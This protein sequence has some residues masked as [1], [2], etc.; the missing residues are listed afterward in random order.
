VTDGAGNVT[1]H[2]HNAL[3]QELTL[4]ER[5]NREVR[6]GEGDYVTERRFNVDGELLQLDTPLGS[7]IHYTYDVPGIDRYREGNVLEVRYV[8]DLLSAGGRGDGHG[9][10]AN[11]LVTS[12]TYEPVFNDVAS[13]TEPRGNDSSYIP[14]NG[15][16]A[17][18][19]R[20]TRRCTFDYQEGLFADN[21]I[22]DDASRWGI[23]LGTF[24]EGL[25]DVNGDGNTSQAFGNAVECRPPA[26]ALAASSNQAGIEGDT[27][28]DIITRF[29]YDAF[30]RTI[31]TN[32]AEGNRHEISYYPEDD[33]DGDGNPTPPPPDGRSLDP[34]A[35]G[36]RA[37]RSIDVASGAAR[38]NG[39]D[40]PPAD[41]LEE[42]FYDDLGRMTDRIDG[43]GV[44]WTSV[45]NALGELVEH[46][47]ASATRD[48]AGPDGDPS[49]GR[50][51]SGLAALGFRTRYVYDAND[52]MTE[53]HL[54]DRDGGR[55]VGPFVQTSYEYDLLDRI[56]RVSRSAN[57]TTTLVSEYRYDA[58]GN[59]TRIIE[60]ESTE[61][62]GIYDERDLLFQWARGAAGPRGGTPSTQSFDYDGNRNITRRTDGD[63]ELTDYEYDGFD[64]RVRE[65]DEVGGTHEWFYDPAGNVVRDLR[66]G[67]VGGPS[68]TDRFGLGNVDLTD[69]RFRYDELSR[70][71]RVDRSLFMPSGSSPTRV[72]LLQ[73]GSLDPADG[74]VSTVF[75][76]DRK[77]RR[78]FAT[79][80]TG[81][82][83]R[84]DYDG[85]GRLLEKKLPDG[86][87][88][89]WTY[90]G[91]G[92]RVELAETEKS[93]LSTV[94]DELFLT[95]WFYD[96]LGRESLRVD[97]LGQT[98][99]WLYDSLDVLVVESDPNGPPGGTIDRRSVAGAGQSVAIND[100]GNVTRWSHDA[101]GRVLETARILT[102]SGRGDGTPDPAP[103]T[104]NP[105]NPDGLISTTYGWDGN[106]L[107]S[108]R[109]DDAGHRETFTYDNLNRRTMTTH[110]DGAIR[111]TSWGPDDDPLQIDLEM[112]TAV[113]H[114]YDTAG[115]LVQIDVSRGPAV[116]GTTLQSF[117]YDGLG[118]P[119][120]ATDNNEPAD[121]MD[122]TE[123]RT[124]YD[125]LSRVVEQQQ[126]RGSTAPALIDYGWL[127]EDLVTSLTYPSSRQI[128][129]TYD[130]LGRLLSVADTARVESASYEHVGA[131]RLAKRTYDN[132]TALSYLNDPETAASG[133]DGARRPVRLRHLDSGAALLA[134]F[135]YD[136]DG[137]DN[138]VLERRL[139]D[140]DGTNFDGELFSYDSANRLTSFEEGL[141]D[142]SGTLVGAATDAQ[143]F[144]LDGPGNWTEMTRNG[145]CF[146]FTP[147]NLNEY[148]EPQ[149]GGTRV[150]DGLPD[151]THDECGTPAADGLNHAHD[152]SGNLTDTGLLQIAYDFL[153]RP[154]RLFGATGQ[155]IATYTY[156]ALGRRVSRE[157]V[158]SGPLDESR[159]Y[160]YAPGDGGAAGSLGALIEEQDL[161]VGGVARQVVRGLGRPLW[162]LLPDGSSQYFTEDARG[163]VAAIVEGAGPP[164]G[165][166]AG[167]VL[168]RVTCDP[169]LTPVL[170]DANNQELTDPAGARTAESFYDNSEL[171]GAL[172]Y[173]PESGSRGVGTNDDFAGLYLAA[174]RFYNPNDG[175]FVTRAA[176]TSTDPYSLSA[177]PTKPLAE[178]ETVTCQN[179]GGCCAQEVIDGKTERPACEKMFQCLK[180]IGGEDS[181]SDSD[182]LDDLAGAAPEAASI[183]GRLGFVTPTMPTSNGKVTCDNAG[184]KCVEEIDKGV[185]DGPGCKKLA[186]CLAFPTT[187]KSGT[188]ENSGLDL[189][190]LPPPPPEPPIILKPVPG[191][192][193]PLP[194]L[195]PDPV[196]LPCD[197]TT[198]RGCRP[199]GCDPASGRGCAPPQ[200]TDS[201]HRDSAGGFE[202]ARNTGAGSRTRSPRKGRSEFRPGYFA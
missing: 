128:Q 31:A 75:E 138:R 186:N 19:E 27:S 199:D 79:R 139:H 38:N 13:T 151:D 100:H 130:A 54:E 191:A 123:L 171:C 80:D 97:N 157:V 178:C 129:Y 49:T 108:Y 180:D 107:L 55:G 163:S 109:E 7:E 132:G 202:L 89:A 175:R 168:E 162:Q 101:A 161:V 179:A 181:S 187:S 147:N 56:V 154:V 149:S 96:A 90:D 76:Y 121:S 14:D 196:P 6:P 137:A 45:Y 165:G 112:G 62:L 32:D 170:E 195:P 9:G 115:R 136:Y 127:A 174:S 146:Q 37:S 98:V 20:Y 34:T 120:R 152:A 22:A 184:E 131:S 86:S 17:T 50:G 111:Q 21:G 71:I 113:V 4:V 140:G 70:Q 183:A 1:E 65:R 24:A 134:G 159:R 126:M 150:D 23:A 68:P 47:R 106:S 42:Y 53:V 158:N 189:V 92:N 30:G 91:A 194:P 102:A 25:G 67:T 167:P 125:S 185:K 104:S 156:D 142:P 72:P 11:D 135:E 59:L 119:T 169:F 35:G 124:F 85:V 182:F 114:T 58:A 93:T 43:R 44:R 143:S 197:P 193:P 200:T 46:R 16:V 155:P 83:T 40:P 133:Y 66:R 176:G 87:T 144:R 94:A 81:A 192:L 141:I 153:D 26:V 201:L 148:D 48:E 116:E 82:T 73:E 36:Y 10:E 172:T 74:F 51:E 145:T 60:P 52:R 69:T 29:E 63:G 190:P 122:D 177:A 5:T 78:S 57:A 84:F 103:D 188:A 198:G 118:R 164:V 173:D 64:R 117:E 28:Q 12:Y 61:H 77:S 3:G 2:T 15:G 105:D 95:T 166:A 160:L 41:I 99:R 8:A 33:P 18:P 88:V 39:T 110:D